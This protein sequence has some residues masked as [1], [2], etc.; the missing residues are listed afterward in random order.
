[1]SVIH[2]LINGLK[3][4]EIARADAV[5][6]VCG[7]VVETLVRDYAIPRD[8]VRVVP[9]GA[10][11]PDEALEAPIARRWRERFAATLIRP[12]WVVP[13]RLEEQK[14][15]RVLLEAVAEV[16]RRGLDF[17]LVLAGEGSQRGAIEASVAAL[18]L[19]QKVHLLGQ[20]E[21]LGP[22][23]TAADAVVLPSLWEGL[24][25]ALLEALV[26]ARPVVATAV[27]GVPEVMTDEV[28]GQL[29]PPG[30]PMALADAL[31]RFH[32]KPDRALRLGRAGAERVREDFTWRAVV[33]DFEAVYDEVLGLATFTPE[34]PSHAGRR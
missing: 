18:G 25:L 31:E 19:T 23:L 17:S 16:W 4:E 7:A 1:M 11:L 33:R 3:Q 5:T 9:N 30:E 15:H 32:R 8:K 10:D 24:P 20:V 21:D 29:V 14:G 28:H 2:R 12:L 34:T 22:L 6:A 13:A 26:R 27:G